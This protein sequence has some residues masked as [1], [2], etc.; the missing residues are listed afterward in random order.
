[1]NTVVSKPKE[2]KIITRVSNVENLLKSAKDLNTNSRKLRRLF[3][4]N[5]Y[6]KKT[7]LSVLKRYKRRLDSI[8][9]ADEER[10]RKASQRKIKLPPIKKFV[11]SF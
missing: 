3:E 8:E 1:M 10:R 4:K 7:Q 2:P 11:G 5:T 6:Q 9:K